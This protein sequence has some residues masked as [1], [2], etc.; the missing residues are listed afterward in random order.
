[1]KKKRE[2]EECVRKDGE[3][4]VKKERQLFINVLIKTKRNSL[5]F[6][7]AFYINLNSTWRIELKA[8]K[9][10]SKQMNWKS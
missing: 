2:E 6:L 7:I 8:S 9:Q 3:E 10:A 1:M 5:L 4:H